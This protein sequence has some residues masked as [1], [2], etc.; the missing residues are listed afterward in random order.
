MQSGVQLVPSNVEELR[1]RLRKMSDEKLIEY[2]KAARYMVT[3]EANLG[4]TPSA[5]SLMQLEE[6]IAEW[7]R[8]HP[9]VEAASESVKE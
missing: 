2:G 3:P 8:R 5:D 6:C 9:K 7:R 4:K 1:A